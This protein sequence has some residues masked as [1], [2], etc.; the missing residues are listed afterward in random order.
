[1]G[2]E[3]LCIPL[4]AGASGRCLPLHRHFMVDL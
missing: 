2:V 1:M 3:D 4:L